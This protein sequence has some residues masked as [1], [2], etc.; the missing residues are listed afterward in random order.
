[1]RKTAFLHQAAGQQEEAVR[2]LQSAFA[3]LKSSQ[4]QLLRDLA[5]ELEK[6]DTEEA[7]KTWEEVLNL[8][9]ESAAY[10]EEYAEF[11]LAHG[12]KEYAL[13]LLNQVPESA[14]K[15]LLLL[16]YPELR[17]ELN[18]EKENLRAL[19]GKLASASRFQNESDSLKAARYAFENKDYALAEEMVGKALRSSP[20]DLAALKLAGQI[21]K[22]TA[23]IESAIQA[24]E[25]VALYEP[26]N[27]ENKKDLANL[28]LQSRQ[29]EKA[30]DI[31]QELITANGEPSRA[32]LLTYA[33]IAIKAEKP[34]LSIP[35]C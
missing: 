29:P 15:T 32:D 27:I 16:R 6:T 23:D 8:A 28:F 26:A 9:P 5:I 17:S 13:D 4:A 31:Y 34:D 22:H 20:N 24:S 12:E 30:L 11:L 25:L 2:A 19:P 14:Q 3:Q 7:R 35:I 33:D 10:K 18:L 1:L 21:K